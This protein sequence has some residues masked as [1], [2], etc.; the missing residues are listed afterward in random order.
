MTHSTSVTTTEERALAL[1]GTGI[2]PS[3]VAATLGVSESRIS[4]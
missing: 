4:Q 3:V 1:L 2:S